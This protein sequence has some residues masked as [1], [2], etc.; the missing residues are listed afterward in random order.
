MHGFVGGI[1]VGQDVW[2]LCFSC[3]REH[4]KV[5]LSARN[6]VDD[7]NALIVPKIGSLAMKSIQ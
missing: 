3:R 7:V 6:I 1:T 2:E 5:V 4:I